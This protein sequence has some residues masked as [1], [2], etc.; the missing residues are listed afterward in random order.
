MSTIENEKENAYP[1]VVQASG[2]LYW[3]VEVREPVD[4]GDYVV[5][6]VCR[7]EDEA[8][9]VDAIGRLCGDDPAVQID[10]APR[11][12][13]AP[14][15]RMANAGL[16]WAILHRPIMD[17]ELGDEPL[18]WWEYGDLC[19]VVPNAPSA[20]RLAATLFSLAPRDSRDEMEFGFIS[21]AE[22]EEERA[23][24]I[25]ERNNF[26]RNFPK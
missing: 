21:A 18:D 8:S 14:G 23:R 20:R 24:A 1:F 11:K 15:S 6:F 3:N 10:V 19:V 25:R 17:E 12:S 16:M 26:F 5:K 7:A 2:L 9:I 22:L 4:G 13:P